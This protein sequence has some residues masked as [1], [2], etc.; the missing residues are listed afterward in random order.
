MNLI[1]FK[2]ATTGMDLNQMLG[3]QISEQLIPLRIVGKDD[4]LLLLDTNV[5]VP[6][7]LGELVAWPTDALALCVR[8]H[9]KLYTVYGYRIVDAVIV[10]G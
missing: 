10:L 9:Q 6:A 3:F 5:D 2:Q 1:D 8:H 7:T 4:T